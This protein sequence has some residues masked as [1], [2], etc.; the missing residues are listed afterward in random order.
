MER[1][2]RCEKC[3]YCLLETDDTGRITACECHRYPEPNAHGRRDVDRSD[4]CGEYMKRN[5]PK[6]G[7]N[8]EQRNSET[9]RK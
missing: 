3:I 4:W 2:N 8:D 7:K 5:E 1:D 9:T 6:K